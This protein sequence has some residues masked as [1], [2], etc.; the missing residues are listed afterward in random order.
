M[1]LFAIRDLTS[2]R[3]IPNLYFSDKQAAKRKRAE[4]GAATHCV[5]FGPDHHRYNPNP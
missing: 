4:L 2:G 1:K 5:T 3:I